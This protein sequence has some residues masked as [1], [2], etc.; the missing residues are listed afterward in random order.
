MKR[1]TSCA[2]VV[3]LLGALATNDAHA[4]LVGGK[5]ATAEVV[6]ARDAS[7]TVLSVLGSKEA[8]AVV[9]AVPPNGNPE[10]RTITPEAIIHALA[11]S[12]TRV[13]EQW[14]QDPCELYSDLGPAPEPS[15]KEPPKKDARKKDA[16]DTAKKDAPALGQIEVLPRDQ[17]K[18]FAALDELGVARSEVLDVAIARYL[19][20][21]WDFVKVPL[22]GRTAS[23]SFTAA[24]F[25][26]PT[27]L[28]AHARSRW[29]TLTPSS[30][31]APR[32]ASFG[33]PTS[34]LV[35]A[36]VGTNVALFEQL[37]EAK[38]Q[39]DR[40]VALTDYAWSASQCDRCAEPLSAAELGALGVASLPSAKTAG[41]VIVHAEAVSDEPGGPEEL[42]EALQKCALAATAEGSP[43]T[44]PLTLDVTKKDGAVAR[45]TKGAYADCVAAATGK[46]ELDREGALE[47]EWSPLSRAFL[48]D[49]VLTRLDL[50]TDPKAPTV[51]EAKP[52]I[53]G[54]RENGPNGKPEARAFPSEG[55]NNYQTRYVVQHPWKGAVKCSAPQR[56]I[57]GPAAPKGW[58][59]SDGKKL[60]QGEAIEKLLL[61]GVPELAAFQLPEPKRTPDAPPD[62]A[63]SKPSVAPSAAPAATPSAA[64]SGT[65]AT[66]APDPGGCDCATP[67]SSSSKFASL[68][69]AVCLALLV[70]WRRA[71]RLR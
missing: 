56:G 49:L 42:R 48:K 45:G 62:P 52:P 57:F 22:V 9:V 65:P 44:S 26:L 29:L 13:V 8:K 58:K 40:P 1:F 27:D 17:V 33:A 24:S 21:G 15:K 30:R 39:G 31:F 66:P 60:A 38:L 2:L 61:D 69:G 64:T 3:S 63:P 59:R 51:L 16:K 35:D 46:A 4:L 70:R 5:G 32:G 20:A 14:E 6:V 50:P 7:T 25:E 41:E 53:E 34:L 43:P 12:G 55:A 23:L 54:G 10:A 47:V 68:F 18:L 36:R 67:A 11:V 19:A 71:R 37:L 28:V